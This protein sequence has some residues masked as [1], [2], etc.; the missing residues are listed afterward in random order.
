MMSRLVKIGLFFL[1]TA[2]GTVVYMMRTADRI[3]AKETYTVDVLMEDA[4]GIFVDTNI[5]MAGVNVGKVRSITLSGGKAKLTLELSSD[6]E[7]YEDAR[8]VKSIESMLGVS[9]LAIHPGVRQENP[10]RAGGM[11][12]NSDS[13]NMMDET[14]VGAA[15]AA[16]EA[17]L[18]MSERRK[19]LSEDGGYN[20]LKEILATA[21]DMTKTTSVLV[22]KNLV[23]LASALEDVAVIT[24]RLSRSSG[25]D[26]DRLSAILKNTA[27]I[28]ER[29][30][31]LLAENDQGLSDT[32]A[33]MRDGM[34]RLNAALDDVRSVTAK[35][36]SGEG[37][38]GKLV[39]DDRL[40]DK[41]V[42]IS[43]QVEEYVNSTIGLDLQVAFQ[44][45]YLVDAA[46]AR[47][48]FGL[49][50][51]PKG[52]AKYYSIGL[53]DTPRLSEKKVT[54]TTV[55]TGSDPPASGTDYT[56]YESERKRELLINAQIARR[57]GLFTLRGG[58][59]ESTVGVGLDFQ[60]ASRVSL[61]A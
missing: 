23:I 40:Y 35:I 31:R 13:A 44:S 34:A 8:I 61:S 17:A 36:N 48:Q 43:T 41:I 7:L 9:A 57:F 51:A 59:I 29:I 56:V 47:S 2:A 6:V 26:I 16:T 46:D 49:R 60:P 12:R 11:I 30:D 1:I 3:V 33:G 15:N 37:N 21:R 22:E 10:L 28:T 39:N 38:V 19:F 4:S 52:G 42:G 54:T 55:I 14:F 18:L 45:D 58:V 32:L 27:A 25:E 5:R 20:T 53:V 50:L 24:D